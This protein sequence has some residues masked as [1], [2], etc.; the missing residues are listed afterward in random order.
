MLSIVVIGKNEAENLQRLAKSIDALIDVC[1][2]PV[3]TLFVDSAST[4]QS[5]DIARTHFDKVI[6]LVPSDGLCA[7]AGRYVGTIAA[8]YPWVFYLDGD[9]EVC[10]Q[11]FSVVQNIRNSEE[12]CMGYVGLYVHH[13]NNGSIAV[14]GFFGGVLKS[15]WAAQFGGAVILRRSAVLRVGNW[16]PSI[17]GKEEMELYARLGDGKRVV[18]YVGVP[19]INHYSEYFTRFELLAR[20]LYPGGGQGKVFYG[21]GQSIRSLMIKGKIGAL[22]RLDFEPY[23]FFGVLIIGLLGAIFLSIEWGLLW[24]ASLVLFISVLMRPGPV[25]RYLMLPI[26]LA[27]GLTRYIPYFRPE[28]KNWTWNA[29][30]SS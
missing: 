5:L 25:I 15:Q 4:D 26:P 21:F 1:D 13:F 30:N 22:I 2:F 17:Y 10:P 23:I 9:M 28:I 27:M 24:V 29:K 7:S 11:F 6:E 8:R 12:E 19:M 3:E 14:Q 20:L 16:D 18:K